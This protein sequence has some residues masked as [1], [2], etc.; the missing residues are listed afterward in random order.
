M[1]TK[2]SADA[3]SIFTAAQNQ[4]NALLQ[5]LPQTAKAKWDAGVKVATTK[6]KQRL[7]KVEDWI[8]ERHSG[9][10]GA[11]VSLWDDVTGLPGWVTEE[12]DAAEQTF[13]DEICATAREISSDV[14]GIILTCETIIANARSEIAAVFAKLPANLQAWAAGEQAKIGEKLD[15]LSKHAHEVRDN[16]NKELIKSASQAVQDVREQVHALR[17]KAKGLI[18]KIMDAID[19]FLDD[20]V[21]FLI[22]ALLEILGIPPS[23]FW[24]VVAKIKKVI[25]DIADDPMKF[26]NNLMDAIGKGFSQFFDHIPEHLLRGFIDWLTGGLASLGVQLPK[27]A[28]LKSILTFMLQLMGITWPRIRKLL[29][30]HIGAKNVALIEK[31]YSLVATFIELGPEGV[32]ELIKE[33]LNPKNILDMIIKAAVDYVIKAVVKAVSARIIL[34]FNPVGAILQALEA[35]YRVLKWIFTN[36][37]RIFRLIETV[38]NGVADILAGN[39]GGMANAVETALAG[40]IAPVIDFLADYLGFGDLPNTIRETI[41]G[42]QEKV[43][44]VLE[45]VLVWLIEKGKALLAAL[46]LGKKEKDK[47]EDEGDI[48]KKLTWT[49]GEE[50]HQLWVALKGTNAVVMMSSEK[51]GPVAAHLDD[52]EKKANAIKSEADADK[53]TTALAGIA[54]ARTALAPVDENA[55]QAASLAKKPEHDPSEFKTK[56][57]QVE[58]GEDALKTPLEKIQNALPTTEIP[59]TKV[60]P[61]AGAKASSITAEPLTKKAGNTSGSGPFE[62]PP[63]WQHVVK[64]DHEL[65]NPK[66]AQ[67][68]PA[69]W[70]RMHL[71]S[72]LLHGPGAAWNL[73][74]ARKTDN[75]AMLG[76]PETDA[77]ERIA[78]DE[79]LYYQVKLDFHSGKIVEDFPSSVNV[80]Y[81]SLK[82]EKNKTWVRA[83]QIGTLPLSPSP[84]PLDA[85]APIPIHTKGREALIDNYDFPP[86]LARNI[87]AESK[88]GG[89]RQT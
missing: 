85:S 33:Q 31:V 28:S 37:A 6:F 67:W 8:K 59:E 32:F 73:V 18:G 25:N 7:K 29:V 36:A 16:F 22:E 48:G 72:E 17:E 61:T 88:N 54:E 23:A 12:Y 35:I 9:G 10:W 62:D 4:V 63:G 83:A 47:K 65:L 24:A 27:D 41:E 21:K 70:V 76:G 34:L 80:V 13:G 19:R 68:G 2:A 78:K 49:T 66:T 20:P 38:V 86:E 71:L 52:Y 51:P 64:I 58:T 43:M 75:S 45:A 40:L 89:L 5:P 82:Q 11:V 60:E 79:V 1:R 44:E 50:P 15:G 26:A 77:K 81:G 53:K 42:F 57:Q 84:P 3:Q 74:P 30:K 87:A 46:G 14:N 55:D 39:I 69:Y 56:E